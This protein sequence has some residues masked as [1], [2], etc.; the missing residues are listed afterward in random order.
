MLA[1]AS[2]GVLIYPARGERTEAEIPDEEFLEAFQRNAK[3]IE[4]QRNGYLQLIDK[5]RLVSLAKEG[6]FVI[7]LEEKPGSFDQ[8]VEMAVRALSPGINDPFT[9]IACVDHLGAALCRLAARDM[10]N[11]YFYDDEQK[12]RLLGPERSFEEILDAAFNQIRQ[13]SISSASVTIRL[14]DT[15]GVILKFVDRPEDREALFR[16]ADMVVCGAREGLP[17]IEDRQQVEARRL[18]L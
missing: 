9:A 18:L 2:V 14:L 17:E 3:A 16:H 8:L 6:D 1:V 12:L 7:R 15:I 4:S 10:P 13:Y 5:T 11:P